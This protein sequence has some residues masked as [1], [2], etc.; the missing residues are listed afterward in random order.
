M[1][2]FQN[3]DVVPDIIASAKGLGCGVPVGAF[4]A[5]KKCC[6]SL[7]P[8]DHGTTY[9][10]NP[11]A[12]QAVSTVLDIYEKENVLD[13]VKVVGAYLEE[14]LDKIVQKQLKTDFLLYQQ[15]E[16]FLECCHRLL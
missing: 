7:V 16:M 10:G 4:I 5:G 11:L 6:N 8:G 13:N 14:Q 2:A 1:F 9:G 12:T 3:Y 15:G